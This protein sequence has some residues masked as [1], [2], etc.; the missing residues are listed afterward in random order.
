MALSRLAGN[1]LPDNRGEHGHKFTTFQKKQKVLNAVLSRQESNRN[2]V[3]RQLSSAFLLHRSR[4]RARIS[5]ASPNTV[6]W[7]HTPNGPFASSII[8]PT[9]FWLLR[10]PFGQPL[11]IALIQGLNCRWFIFFSD[12]IS[13]AT[14]NFRVA[15]SFCLHQ[16]ASFAKRRL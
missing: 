13:L 5:T 4:E 2:S 6:C 1:S 8:L 10:L 16:F 7:M 14:R 3:W 11:W 9:L 15:D 12:S